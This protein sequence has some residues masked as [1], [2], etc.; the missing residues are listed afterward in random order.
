[1]GNV[2]P[3]HSSSIY[4]T[5]T[6]RRSIMHRT[7]LVTCGLVGVA[8]FLGLIFYAQGGLLFQSAPKTPLSSATDEVPEP[9]TQHDEPVTHPAPTETQ[10]VEP[11]PV[12]EK[13][14]AAKTKPSQQSCN[15]ELKKAAEQKYQTALSAE[16]AK[17]KENSQI[18]GLNRLFGSLTGSTKQKR[19]TEAARHD[20][21]LKA[22]EQAYHRALAD[23]G[24]S[25]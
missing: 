22:N 24:C 14:V 3:E 16:N 6:K 20:A 4:A 12:P 19:E 15:Q 18:S 21:A 11:L 17:H 25:V 23:A 8:I 1:M 10:A 9:A 7:P 5:R 2:E 13:T